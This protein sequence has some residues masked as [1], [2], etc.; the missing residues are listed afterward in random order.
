MS[1]RKK[2][3][4]VVNVAGVTCVSEIGEFTGFVAG[5]DALTL[6]EAVLK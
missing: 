2:R 5:D 3:C 6:K 4:S 1:W